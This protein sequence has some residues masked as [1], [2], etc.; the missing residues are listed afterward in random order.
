MIV[1]RYIPAA[2]AFFLMG[3]VLC[4]PAV[5]CLS[6][7]SRL[8]PSERV[9]SRKALGGFCISYTH[10]VNKGRVHD[11]YRTDGTVLVLDRTSFVSYGAGIPEAYET[12]GAVFS[13]D[14]GS[15]EI[16]NLNRRLP[17]LLMA[18]GVIAEHAISIDDGEVP[19]KTL[20]VPQTSVVFE[21]K[22]VPLIFYLISRRI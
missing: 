6:L 3:I 9:L 20:F 13:V 18:V 22:T 8:R 1:R 2:V 12:E 21:V 16:T 11:Y 14:G 10:S 19:L 17:R 15:Y 4:V 5:R 7:S